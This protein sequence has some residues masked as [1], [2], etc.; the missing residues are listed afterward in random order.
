MLP[1]RIISAIIGIFVLLVVL[2]SKGI[3]FFSLVVLIESF[4]YYEFL[5]MFL[6]RYTGYY[7]SLGLVAILSI[8]MAA[9]FR[10]PVLLIF[11]LLAALSMLL[12]DTKVKKQPL[13]AL[14]GVLYVSL[15]VHLI[16]LRGISDNGKYL[17][18]MVFLGTWAMDSGAYF[19]GR[20][21]GKHKIT[22]KLSPNK[23]WEGLIAGIFF[24]ALAMALI[25]YPWLNILNR[26][27][28]GFVII[29]G[30]FFGDLFESKLKRIAKV[31]DAGTAIPGHGGFLDRFDSLM[32]TGTLVFYLV[33]IL[34]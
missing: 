21:F 27:L 18:L 1:Y 6:S 24:V 15:L 23:T 7:Y 17:V 9:F 32:L 3:Y 11:M 5:Q 26:F 19:I 16:A 28:I 33:L 34:K 20:F 14:L 8:S 12:I 31:K 30:A 4:A 2:F 10:S 29:I 13:V 22:P 25:P